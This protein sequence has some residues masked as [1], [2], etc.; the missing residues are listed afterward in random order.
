MLR[1]TL[2][3]LVTFG[4][5]STCLV[6][7]AAA[8]SPSLG[9]LRPEGAQRGTEVE[10]TFNGQRLQDAK[11]ILYLTPGIETVSLEAGNDKQVKAKLRIK[12]DCRLGEH[13]MRVRTATGISDMRVFYVGRLPRKA[14]KEPN[15]EFETAQ[16]IDLDVTVEGTIGREDIDYFVVDLKAG[17][18]LSLEVE[19]LRLGNGNNLFDPYIA[20]LDAKRFE[21]ISSDDAPLLWQDCALS[22]QAPSDGSYTIAVRDSSYTGTGI[23]HLHVGRFPRPMAV[24]PAGGK[25]GEEVEVKFLGDA[26]GDLVQKAKLP[27]EKEDM[28][29]LF[30]QDDRGLAPSGNVFRLSPFGNTLESEPNDDYKTATSGEMPTALNGIIQ[31][32]GDVDHFKVTLKKGEQFELNCYARRLRSPLDPVLQI[33][34]KDGKNLASN[35]DAGGSPDST[36]RFNVPADG[37]YIV[38]VTDH[39]GRGGPTFVY[40]VEFNTFEPE[41]AITIPTF[42]RYQQERH[43]IVVPKGNRYATIMTATKQNFNGELVFDPPQLPA[44]VKMT[45]PTMPKNMNVVPVLFEAAADAP[46]AGLL[47][48]VTIRDPETKV[49]GKYFQSADLVLGPNQQIYWKYRATQMA[50]SVAEEAPFRLDLVQPNVPLVQSGTMQLKVVATRKEGFKDPITLQFPFR[51][52]GVNAASSVTIAE[53]Q[54][55]AFYPIN[56]AGNAELRKWQVLVIGSAN[57]NGNVWVSTGYIDLE[58]AAPF[59]AFKFKRE[60]IEQGEAAEILVKVEQKT[61]FEGAAKVRLLGLP[62]QLGIPELEL[63]K[64]M[65]ELVFKIPTDDKSPIGKHANLFC[66]VVVIQKDEPVTHSL[67][68]TELQIDKPLP[69]AV[70][71][72]PAEKKP[73]GAKPA[74]QKP[75]E[76]KLSRLERLR[77]EAEARAKAE[78][79]GAK[80]RAEAGAGGS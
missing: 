21:L 41:V 4:L 67:G 51:P 25:L 44:G 55:E 49:A 37:E 18:R 63:T 2:A 19:G 6:G 48:D 74:E 27:V 65:Q 34:N 13:A 35:D 23:Y 71:V 39:L 22:F 80:P 59:I 33:L 42:A 3:S 78:A 29:V 60:A 73:E 53:G 57:I 68:K 38:R 32:T 36:F 76:K 28:F 15:T 56:A 47:T 24:Y 70:A 77:L 75:A 45:V 64:D 43:A 50:I 79:S 52:N 31:Q 12:P 61:P 54:T 5:V 9:N 16:K 11:E 40:R 72:A 58:V 66:E 17:E 46:E 62:Q 20:I 7:W 26:S 10:V 69:K 30:A 8:A 1:P 14:E